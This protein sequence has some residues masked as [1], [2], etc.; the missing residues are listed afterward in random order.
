M[1]FSRE[2]SK[3]N[4]RVFTTIRGYNSYQEGQIILIRSPTREF[5]ARILLKTPVKFK[6]IPEELLQYDTD[7]PGIEAAVIRQKIRELY[8][9]YDPP[10]DND[11]V[12]IYLLEK[13][14]QNTLFGDKYPGEKC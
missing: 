4:D 8:R 11:V 9:Q 1:K 7:S 5:R 13:V 10:Q 12:F 14:S 3:L 2:Y 6:E